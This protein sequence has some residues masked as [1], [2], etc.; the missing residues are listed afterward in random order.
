MTQDVRRPGDCGLSPYG[1]TVA[2]TVSPPGRDTDRS[3]ANRIWRVSL[4]G[5]HQQITFGPGADH[6]P[7]F[8]PDGDR[9]AFLLDR[10]PQGK[11]SQYL[12]TDAMIGGPIGD[13]PGTFEKAVWSRDGRSIPCIAADEGLDTPSSHGAVPLAWTPPTGPAIRATDPRR[14]RF[15]V[16]VADGTTSDIGSGQGSVRDVDLVPDGSVLALPSDDPTERGWHDARLV[17]M[18]SEGSAPEIL[19]LPDR[20]L[21]C[22]AISPDERRAATLEAPA[23]DRTLVA[24]RLLIFDLGGGTLP[25]EGAAGLD[26]LTHVARQIDGSPAATGWHGFGTFHP[27]LDGDGALIRSRV[28]RAWLGPTRFTARRATRQRRANR[29][30]LHA[31]HALVPVV[32]AASV[33]AVAVIA[34]SVH[35]EVSFAFPDLGTLLVDAVRQRDIP[36]I[37]GAT[38]AFPVFVILVKVGSAMIYAVF[39][40]RIRFRMADR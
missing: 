12:Q 39:D 30:K 38:L 7:A 25:V 24:G 40:P 1:A 10:A 22:P 32:T 29:R 37:Q 31:A 4:D 11:F 5:S 3:I 36:L 26:D 28:D 17:R 23:S 9:F 34:G 20:P 2:V 21:Q 35:L 15:G 19:H 33:I 6:G 14:H 8:A 16:D 13:I 27:A 18:P